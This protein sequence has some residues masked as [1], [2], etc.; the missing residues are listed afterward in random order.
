VDVAL[1]KAAGGN[2]ASVTFKSGFSARALLGLLAS[3]DL[4]LKV[5]PDGTAYFD[6][7]TVDRNTGR[8]SFPQGAQLGP[9]ATDPSSPADGT[10]WYNSTTSQVRAR[11]NGATRILAHDDVAFAQP[12]T[13]DHLTTSMGSGTTTGTA[14]GVVGRFDIFPFV[15]RGDFTA[16]LIAVN[17]STAVAAAQGKLVIYGSNAL[18]QP[19]NLIFES[20]ALD[21][22]TTGFKSAAI[23]VAFR[24]GQVFWMGIRHSS[25]AS[26]T[27]FAASATPDLTTSD[28]TVQL[29]KVLRRTLAFATAAPDPWGYLST[30]TANG[31]AVATF[32]RSA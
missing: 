13:G 18:G 1:N 5:S 17:V 12:G 4:T 21:F 30:Q 15:P 22:S 25:T 20:A 11:L 8:V 10:I 29:R 2:D 26:T 14:A 7:L 3:E 6:G 24:K 19:T 32:L 27:T 23:N 16:D 31:S 9:L 28:L